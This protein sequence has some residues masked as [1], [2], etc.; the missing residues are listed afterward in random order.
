M[1]KPYSRLFYSLFNNESSVFTS[2]CWERRCQYA[3]PLCNARKTAFILGNL[4]IHILISLEL[5]YISPE[6]KVR[7]G[8]FIN[9][10]W[11]TAECE[12]DDIAS[13]LTSSTLQ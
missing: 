4:D 10:G 7:D 5:P 6:L 1:S 2:G 11:L 13:T 9:L 3:I 12:R 8:S